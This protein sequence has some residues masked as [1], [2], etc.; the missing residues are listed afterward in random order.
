MVF[1]WMTTIESVKACEHILQQ[2]FIEKITPEN[3]SI[4]FE[5][6]FAVDHNIHVNGRC[7]DEEIVASITELPDD[8]NS[9]KDEVDDHETFPIPTC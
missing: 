3:Q 8:D 9:D 4:L 1:R 6:Y 7:N 5:D 2:Q